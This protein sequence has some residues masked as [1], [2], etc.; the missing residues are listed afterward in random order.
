MTRIKI[1]GITNID[2]ALAAVELGADAVGFVFALSP[3]RVDASK[4][5]AISEAIPPFV[6]RVGVFVESDPGIAHVVEVCGLDAVQLHGDQ[7]ETLARELAAHARVIRV[8]RV[9]DHKSLARLTTFDSAHAFLL[10]TYVGDKYG[11]TGLTFNWELAAKAKEFGKP[12]ILSGGLSP[13]NVE[14][15]IR[16]ARPYAVDVSSG[17]E[18]EPGRKD[19]SKMK[20]FIDNVRSVDAAS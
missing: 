16:T 5:K 3:R 15:A 10:D 1:C 19:Y 8:L 2:D 14:E 12:V 13:D 17:V 11:G 18:S 4:A 9:K 20:E 6:T 7:G